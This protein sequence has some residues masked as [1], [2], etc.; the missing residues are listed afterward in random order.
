MNLRV[1][2]ALD[3]IFSYMQGCTYFFLFLLHKIDC[4]YSLESI[5]EAVLTCNHN[6]CFEQKYEK[7]KNTIKIFYSK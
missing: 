2:K 7:Y 3:A 5:S 6:L 1:L 4:G